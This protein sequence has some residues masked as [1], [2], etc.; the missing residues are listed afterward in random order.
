MKLVLPVL[1]AALAAGCGASQPPREADP[2]AGKPPERNSPPAGWLETAAGS[3]WLAR[4][5]F[6]WQFKNH[7]VCA[8]AVA[9]SCD[10]KRIPQ[11]EVARGELVRAHLGFE[12]SEASVEGAS[13]VVHGR[14]VSWKPTRGGAFMLFTRTK[15]GDVS[16]YGCAVFHHETFRLLRA[17]L[18]RFL[19]SSERS[20]ASCFIASRFSSRCSAR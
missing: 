9:P 11:V 17:C 20:R 18:T 7:G 3:T 12:P 6:C 5:S 4:G 10:S 2:P 8:D 13:T 1:L 19:R 16:Y 14:T 15:G